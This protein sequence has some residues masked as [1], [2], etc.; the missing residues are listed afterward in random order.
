[1]RLLVHDL[2]LGRGALGE[3]GDGGDIS[4][5][6]SGTDVVGIEEALVGSEQVEGPDGLA[7]KAHR[8][9]MDRAEPGGDGAGRELGPAVVDGGELLVHDR[10]TG[11]V[12]L[13]ARALLGLH[14]E[15]L[16]DPHGVAR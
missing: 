14:L 6:L 4:E 7:A 3:D 5:G 15:E 1:M 10:N 9:R 12:A 16:Q 2:R 13:R 11:A 8:Q